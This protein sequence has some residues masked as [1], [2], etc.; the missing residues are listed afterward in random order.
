MEEYNQGE[1][2]KNLGLFRTDFLR[3]LARLSK[4]IES[5]EKHGRERKYLLGKIRLDFIIADY[6]SSALDEAGL[7]DDEFLAGAREEVESYREAFIAYKAR[8]L[9]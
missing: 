1:I 8:F 5:S 2:E 9:D 6:A 7:K 4:I 3:S